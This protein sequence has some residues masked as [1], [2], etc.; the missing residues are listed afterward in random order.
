MIN[1]ALHSSARDHYAKAGFKESLI[2]QAILGQ[3]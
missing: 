2:K 3:A 1:C